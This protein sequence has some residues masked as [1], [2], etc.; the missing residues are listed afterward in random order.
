MILIF[1][2]QILKKILH[3]EKTLTNYIMIWDGFKLEKC[4]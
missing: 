2:E 4:L 3:V 1:T